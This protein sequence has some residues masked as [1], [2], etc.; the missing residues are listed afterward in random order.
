MRAYQKAQAAQQGQANQNAENNDVDPQ[1]KDVG[2]SHALTLTQICTRGIIAVDFGIIAV[3]LEAPLCEYNGHSGTEARVHNGGK[4]V[5]KIA[6][7]FFDQKCLDELEK[8]KEV[9]IVSVVSGANNVGEFVEGYLN[10]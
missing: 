3:S 2:I 8:C 1:E 10:N 5:L 9:Q 4:D 6:C 7:G